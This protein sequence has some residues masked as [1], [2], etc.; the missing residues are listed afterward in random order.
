MIEGITA[1]EPPGV[2]RSLQVKMLA[3]AFVVVLPAATFYSILFRQIVN[4]PFLDDYDAVLGFLNNLV[5]L[6]GVSEKLLFFLTAR[7]NEYKLF[8][9]D[10]SVW[11]QTALLG[12]VNFKILCAAGNGF[13]LLLAILL[14]KMFLPGY[15]DITAKLMLFLPVTLLIFQL[16]YVETLNWAMPSLQ[17][18]PSLVFSLAAIYFLMRLSRRAYYCGAAGLVLAIAASGNGLLMVP[19][20]AVILAQ[21]GRYKRMAGWLIISAGCV[22]VYAYRYGFMSS[23]SPSHRSIFAPL[24]HARPLYLLTLMGNATAP[25]FFGRVLLV[26]ELYCPVLALA[27]CAFYIAM[28]QRGY[29][30]RNAMVGYCVL[31]L[32]LTELGI[33]GLRS[34]LGILESLS[35]RYGMYSLLILIFAWFA[36]VEEYLLRA[37]GTVQKRAV[38]GVIAGTILFSAGMDVFGWRYLADRDRTLVQG[39]IAFEDSSAGPVLPMTGQSTSMNEF[40][41]HARAVLQ[42][43]MRLGIYQPPEY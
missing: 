40:D 15:K 13:V 42:E 8:F 30:R 38:A 10:G 39:M 2:P 19:I 3:A 12:H 29:F 1:E 24:I 37:N 21:R 7:H 26:S 25:P 43:S 31:F 36:I 11:L 4:L 27:L 33:T 16:Q 35:S 41:Q 32:L 14:W 5:E 28:V 22:A 17:H 6:R 23:L 20:G 9:V 34:E 18:L